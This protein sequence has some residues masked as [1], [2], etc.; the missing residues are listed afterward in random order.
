MDGVMTRAK[1]RGWLP[2]RIFF[3]GGEVMVSWAHFAD[4]KLAEP[5]FRDS[6]QLAMR[7]PFNQ[8]F[9]QE[10]SADEMVAWTSENPGLA[11]TAFIFHASRCGSTLMSQML[12]A[13]PSHIV[14]SEP[15]MLDSLLRAQFFAGGLAEEKQLAYVRALVAALGQPRWSETEFVIK[16]DAWNVFELP[17][18]RRAFPD[19]PWIFLYRDPLEIA[20]SQLRQRASYMVPGMIGPAQWMIEP[21]EAMAMGEE[22]YI[23]RILGR[24][25]EQGVRML[26]H[27]GGKAVH[28]N[29]LPVAM[30]TTLSETFGVAGN[31][32]NIDASSLAAM[33]NAAKWD[34]KNPYFEFTSDAQKKQQEA[35]P[36]LR[37]AVT[38]WVLPHYA[39]LER[40]RNN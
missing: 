17:L 40:L 11:P 4:R 12:A 34:A 9:A 24:I 14:A 29:Q 7:L 25:F 15:P 39:E 16:L 3:R 18:M 6:A 23:A 32:Q 37:E 38:Q 28:Y 2:V 30:W 19:T 26:K 35:S 1:L 27:A 33:Q 10:T 36:R 21:A 20:V 5:F 8:A 13:L 31:A 22:E